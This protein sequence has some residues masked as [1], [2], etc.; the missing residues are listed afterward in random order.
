MQGNA[1]KAKSS[2]SSSLLCC[3]TWWH[4]QC[5][6]KKLPGRTQ[7][8][9]EDSASLAECHGLTLTMQGLGTTASCSNPFPEILEWV[10]LCQKDAGL[11]Q[12]CQDYIW[13]VGRLVGWKSEKVNK[14]HIPLAPV[15]RRRDFLA[16]GGRRRDCTEK[17]REN[18]TWFSSKKPLR[19]DSSHS[20]VSS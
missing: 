9:A 16:K 19:S 8:Q 1:G 6:R 15:G 11:S 17:P 5:W 14:Q 20:S 12:A 3:S 13:G 4:Q 2:G 7:R 18:H 10:V